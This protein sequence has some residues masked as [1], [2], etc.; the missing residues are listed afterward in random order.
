[1]DTYSNGLKTSISNALISCI[2][3]FYKG[4]FDEIIT[5]DDASN[6]KIDPQAIL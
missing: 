2:K 3:V 4:K 6:N 1:M 5:T